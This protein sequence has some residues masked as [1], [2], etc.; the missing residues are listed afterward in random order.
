MSC[1][2]CHVGP[3]PINPPADPENPQWANLN[4]N[5][6]AQYFWT[7][8]IFYWSAD[9][10]NFVYQ[11]FH[12]W[13]PGTLDTSFVSS[14]N[15]VNPRTMN[16]VYSVMPRLQNSKR[17]KEKLAGGGL[18]NKQF[19]DFDRT[20]ILSDLFQPPDTVAAAR[21]LKDGSDSVGVLGAL[22][23]VY[24]N[25]GL[26]S[27]EWL[28]HFKPLI[29][30]QKISPIK[31][32]DLQANS[33]YWNA[34]VQQTP[35]VA[36]FFLKTAKPDRLMD[37]PGGKGYLTTNT[38]KLTRGKIVFAENCA[39]CHSSKQP[40]LC[41]TPQN[42][43]PG[44]VLESSATHLDWLRK[45]VVKPDFL[46][47]NFLSTEKR[48]PVTELGTNACSPLASNAIGGNIWD[49]FSSQTYK[50]LPSVGTITVYNPADGSPMQFQMPAGGRGYTRPASLIS[51]W[52]TAPF[53]LNNSVGSFHKSPSVDERMKAFNEAIQ[54]MLWPEKRARDP[55][56]GDNVPGDH[57]KIAGPS[58]IQR[59][60][61]RSYLK[62][63]TGY[64]PDALKDLLGLA[65]KDVIEIGPIPE[66]TPVGL[67]ANLD[68]TPAA[69]ETTAQTL[70]RQA[71]L[72]VLLKKIIVALKQVKD[73]SDDEARAVFRNVVPDLMKLS[74]CPDY[75]INKGHYFGTNLPD[76]DK[77]ALIEFI[78]TF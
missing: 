72:V 14:D 48:I 60:T 66:G 45:E 34:N 53:L 12:A 2:F 22:N 65:N 76:A 46:D 11:L 32:A 36:L 16:A 4:S 29:G 21:V 52:S 10:T 39:R 67:L 50:D 71:K 51:V 5:P 58:L 6:G 59:T 61:K 40:P 54:Q 56:L 8:R 24:I 70:E 35:D 49:N 44:E 31:I 13:L 69:D 62:V 47:G 30:G 18:L 63:A 19:N 73:K 75:V 7:D 43:K 3:S 38:K 74:K 57:P 37:A 55:K 41:D 26:F 20:K 23:R 77:F 15:I 64:L 28:L 9:E 78:K 68:L 17:W 33:S 42:C 27:E 1:G 25:I